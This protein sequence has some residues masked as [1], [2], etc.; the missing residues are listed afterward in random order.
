MAS[1]PATPAAAPTDSAA[2]APSLA[3]SGLSTS[4]VGYAIDGRAVDRIRV[5]NTGT[6]PARDLLVRLDMTLETGIVAHLRRDGH[7]CEHDE[8]GTTCVIGDLAAGS[9]VGLDVEWATIPSLGWRYHEQAS[10]TI[11]AMAGQD[12]LAAGEV[13]AMGGTELTA[14]DVVVRPSAPSGLRVRTGETIDVPVTLRLDGGAPADGI[15]LRADFGSSA[16]AFILTKPHDTT[17]IKSAP[18]GLLCYLPRQREVTFRVTAKRGAARTT[19]HK[20]RVQ[21]NVANAM[22]RN[23]GLDKFG[24]WLI[25]PTV[26]LT[27]S[28]RGNAQAGPDA[29]FAVLSPVTGSHAAAQPGGAGSGLPITGSSAG[30]VGLLSVLAGG[31]VLMLARRRN[32]L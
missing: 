4:H 28:V 30:M 14:R 25:P 27:V 31:L 13:R 10:A 20:L 11:K 24:S 32:R 6:A 2:A 15:F 9:S 18:R 3:L 5:T 26:P 1:A 22:Q 16:D 7:E 17:C 29:E 19:A 12:V 21:A 8:D 23:I